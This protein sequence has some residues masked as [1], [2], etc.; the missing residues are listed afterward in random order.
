M[1]CYDLKL[2]IQPLND[3]ENILKT[4][5]PYHIRIPL[6]S[7]NIELVQIFEQRGLNLF[8]AE[9]FHSEPQKITVIHTDL[10]LG[11]YTK[12]NYVYG[13]RGSLMNW[14]SVNNSQQKQIQRTAIN[15]PYTHYDISECTLVQQAQVGFP[16]LVQVGVPHN[17]TNFEEH[18]FCLSLVY[19]KSVSKQRL[20]MQESLILFDDLL[21]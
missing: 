15:T 14:Y 11:D 1:N 17:V 7:I 4:H 13:G 20:S 12:I 10:S 2:N 9:L 21:I 6:D 19:R 16:S 18:R 5:L 3:K 8:L